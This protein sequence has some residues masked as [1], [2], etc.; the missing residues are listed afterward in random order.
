MKILFYG[1]GRLGNQVFQYQA[2][3]NLAGSGGSI[4]AV[5]LEDMQASLDL[6]GP[7]L[8]VV[9][10][11]K[12]LK[13]FVKYIVLPCILRPLCRTLR[14]TGYAFE[15]QSGSGA[16]RR[17]EGEMVVRP[18][19]LRRI[20]FVD[21]GGYQSEAHWSR[22]FPATTLRLKP[23]L[24]HAAQEYLDASN[25]EGYPN[26]FVHVRR[27]DYLTFSAYGVGGLTLPEFYYRGAIAELRQRLRRL[28]PLRLVFVTDD[29][30]WVRETFADIEPKS[31]ASFHP[32]LDFAI[33]AGCTAG[34]VSN[35]TFS[36]AAAL[37]LDNPQLVIGPQY[38][39]GFRAREWL[40]PRIRFDRPQMLYLPAI[41]Q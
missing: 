7:P 20:V 15:H 38:W 10:R 39:L 17:A 13:R 22:A 28:G 19:L 11:S 1:E 24:Q 41:A 18:G 6:T 2:L 3:S 35:S 16:Q 36:L 40:P 34:I 32:A 25:P 4:I 23:E 30:E 14:L 5:G 9:C 27:G 21:G 8:R 37:L 26:A 33:M 29:P 31:I 12:W